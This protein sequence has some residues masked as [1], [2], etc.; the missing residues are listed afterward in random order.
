MQ[1]VFETREDAERVECELKLL[2]EELGSQLLNK[3][4]ARRNILP[5]WAPQRETREATKAFR[6]ELHR[7]IK[8]G[9]RMGEVYK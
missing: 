4:I 5:S 6:Q 9:A 1:G 8:E 3:G 2:H 7:M